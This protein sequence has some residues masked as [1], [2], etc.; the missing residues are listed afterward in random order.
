MS[1]N[2]AQI[3][4]QRKKDGSPSKGNYLV[5]NPEKYIGSYPIIYRSSWEFAF[6]KFCDINQNVIKWSTE[7]IEIP[8]QIMNNKTQ[9]LETHRYYPDFYVE[10]VN[11]NDKETYNRLVIEIKPKSETEMPVQPKK[12]TLKMLENFEYAQMTYKKN[13]HKWAFTKEWCEKRNLHF[14]IITEEWLRSKGLIP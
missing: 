9:M 10:T 13:L 14:K 3:I 1:R 5:Q 8:Y 2:R 4:A 11:N 7:G 6:C 12:Q